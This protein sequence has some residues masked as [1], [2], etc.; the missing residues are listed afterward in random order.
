MSLVQARLTI[1]SI[2]IILVNVSLANMAFMSLLDLVSYVLRILT[3][4][5]LV[6]GLQLAK[7]AKMNIMQIVQGIARHAHR[8]VN[9]A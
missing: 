1:V 3:T 2:A 9:C 4:V 8:G 5:F 7:S 6:L